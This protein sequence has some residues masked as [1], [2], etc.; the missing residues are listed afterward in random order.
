MACFK[1]L[2]WNVGFAGGRYGLEGLVGTYA[3]VQ[4]R[5]SGIAKILSAVS[6]DVVCLQEIDRCSKRSF[7]TDQIDYLATHAGYPYK[8]FVQTWRSP[9]IPYPMTWRVT[10]QFGPMDAG[11][12]I[13][14]RHP[15]TWHA[16]LTHPKPKSRSGLFKYFYLDRVSQFV[17]IKV[18]GNQRL[19]V[20]HVHL[21]AFDGVERM[22]QA[23][24]L[25]DLIQRWGTCFQPLSL[26]GDFNAIPQQPG[27]K[28]SFDDEPTLFYGNDATI[29][30]FL[31]SG[32]L[33]AGLAI[34]DQDYPS[35][36]PNRQLTHVFHSPVMGLQ[37]YTVL[38]TGA[39]SDHLPGLAV[40]TI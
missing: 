20:G 34:S 1:V 21:E 39:L 15:I 17:S 27:G 29:D 33:S 6:A 28:Y 11:Q 40:Y 5:L 35:W 10:R 31:S 9:W 25:A 4:S 14:S 13:L 18:A 24:T 3:D 32:L 37:S 2:T 26:C 36:D 7:Y 16:H 23:E 22:A 8:A 12:V 19:I 38:Q 30:S